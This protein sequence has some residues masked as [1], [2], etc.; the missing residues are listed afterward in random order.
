MAV[1]RQ[2]LRQRAEQLLFRLAVWEAK[3]PTEKWIFQVRIVLDKFTF[4]DEPSLPLRGTPNPEKL[5]T[6]RERR[7]ELVQRVSKH[8]KEHNDFDRQLATDVNR[9]LQDYAD[10]EIR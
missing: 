3:H 6:E 8:F 4:G 5:E 7:Q 10:A 9:L 1:P 2:E